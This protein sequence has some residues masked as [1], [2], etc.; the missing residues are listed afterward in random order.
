MAKPWPPREGAVAQKSADAAIRRAWGLTGTP[1]D[2]PIRKLCILVTDR[3]ECSGR[4]SRRCDGHG[5]LAQMLMLVLA[6]ATIAS[7]GHAQPPTCIDGIQNG[8]ETGV[9]CGGSCP[10]CPD[11]DVYCFNG[12]R[13][14]DEVRRGRIAMPAHMPLSPAFACCLLRD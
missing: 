5:R 4:Q 3:H 9:D 6:A 2:S 8:A 1:S 10:A 13:D 12:V 7:V 14:E 11:P